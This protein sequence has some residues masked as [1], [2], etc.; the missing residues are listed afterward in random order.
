MDPIQ[1]EVGIP[2]GFQAIPTPKH[3]HGNGEFVDTAEVTSKVELSEEEWTSMIV[4]KLQVEIISHTATLPLKQ[5]TR[6]FYLWFL[7]P[8][9][10][11]ALHGFWRACIPKD[12]ILLLMRVPKEPSG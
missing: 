6:P 2:E 8:L 9:T 4:R 3:W 11:Q 10:I 7:Q 1:L 12:R 5:F